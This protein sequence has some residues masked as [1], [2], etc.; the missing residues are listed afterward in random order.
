M[1]VRWLQGTLGAVGLDPF[2]NFHAKTVL[3]MWNQA[4]NYIFPEYPR[5]DDL[6]T[7]QWTWRDAQMLGSFVLWW[8]LA[9]NPPLS[10]WGQQPL[11][12][13]SFSTGIQQSDLTEQHMTALDTWATK[14]GA[15]LPS[16][17]ENCLAANTQAIYSTDQSQITAC[18]MQCPGGLSPGQTVPQPPLPQP[19]APV[20]PPAT[21]PLPPPPAPIEPS[22]PPS[23]SGSGLLIGAAI[24]LAAVGI[25]AAVLTT[26]GGA[27]STR[28][29]PRKKKRRKKNPGPTYGQG[30]APIANPCDHNWTRNLYYFSLG[31]YGSTHLYVWANSADDAM[32]HMVEWADDNAPGLLSWAKSEEDEVDMYV[33]GHTT[34]QHGNVMPAWEIH[35]DEIHGKKRAAVKRLSEIECEDEGPLPLPAGN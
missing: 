1:T 17:I 18:L 7:P 19:P 3:A 20:P 28:A 34:L 25:F 32:E 5:P 35:F 6:L 15:G 29:N 16:C 27:P 33:V 24:I 8:N 21:G 14:S 30:V 22:Q 4:Q 12:N 2:K 31:A 10:N 9:P 11:P 13:P 26:G 23:T